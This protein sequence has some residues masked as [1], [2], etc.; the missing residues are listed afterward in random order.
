MGISHSVT[1]VA[2][3]LKPYEEYLLGGLFFIVGSY[4]YIVA[5]SWGFAVGTWPRLTAG[6]VVIL[7]MLVL[8]QSYLP[9]WFRSLITDGDTMFSRRQNEADTSAP[10]PEY[11]DDHDPVSQALVTALFTVGYALAG[12]LVGLLWATPLFVFTYSYWNET[13]TSKSV[14]LA[15]IGF[16]IA[17]GFAIVLGVPID[18]G[19]LTEAIVP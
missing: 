16:G 9:P 13:E 8:I 18:V 1:T 12:Y 4:A 10:E 14:V 17:Y 2:T 7:S 5:R 3:S 11:T 15:V 6:I 19:V